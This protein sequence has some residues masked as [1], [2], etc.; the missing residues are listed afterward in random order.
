MKKLNELQHILWCAV[1]QY[2]YTD[3]QY[4]YLYN[5]LNRS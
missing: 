4:K 3:V 1:V 2:K 5:T